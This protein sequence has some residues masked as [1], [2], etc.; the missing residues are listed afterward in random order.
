[1]QCPVSGNGGGGSIDRF[2]ADVVGIV[3]RT[4]AGDELTVAAGGPAS[5][6]G[7]AFAAA[8]A[9]DEYFAT[10]AWRDDAG[11]GYLACDVAAPT[12]RV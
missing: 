5:R 10:S 4:W 8:R 12:L 3:Y 2:A 1:M 11:F 9:V 6:S 7:A